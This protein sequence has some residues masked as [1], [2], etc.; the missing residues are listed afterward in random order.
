MPTNPLVSDRLARLLAYHEN[1]AATVRATMELLAARS[2]GAGG[3]RRS[4]A[5]N[6]S[7]GHGPTVIERAALTVDEE[8][9]ERKREQDRQSKARRRAQKPDY[10]GKPGPKP[11]TAGAMGHTR[12]V[13]KQRE[14]SAAALAKFDTK[15]PRIPT[16]IGIKRPQTAIGA[17]VRRGYLA[18]KGGGY[19]RT[20]KEFHIKPSD[21]KAAD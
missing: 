16:E 18:R 13:I 10:P 1:A 9:R 21:A 12:R 15:D 5:F 3:D 20:G 2:T 17:L 6:G 4:A 14:A 11:K 8:R 7:N 19:I